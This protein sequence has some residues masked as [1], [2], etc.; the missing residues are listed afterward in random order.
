MSFLATLSAIAD[1]G[2]D[3]DNDSDSDSGSND[4]SNGDSDGDSD[5]DSNLES[6]SLMLFTRFC[7]G[8]DCDVFKIVII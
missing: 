8:F 6:Y 1:S 5:G 7:Y 4:D 3:S 2:S